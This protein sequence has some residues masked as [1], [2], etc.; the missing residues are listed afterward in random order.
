MAFSFVQVTDHHLTSSESVLTRGFSTNYSF[1]AVMQHIAEYAGAKADPG[2]M[3]PSF[4]VSTGDLGEK[5][6]PGA[7][8]AIGQLLRARM[9]PI[10]MPG[11]LTVSLAGTGET[12]MYFLPGNHD[13]LAVMSRCLFT[14]NEQ[15]RPTSDHPDRL[16]TWFEVG[17]VRFVWLDWGREAKASSTPEMFDFLSLALG[18]GR[19]A[20]ILTHHHVA[21]IGVAWLDGFIADDVHR[22][23]EIVRHKHVLGVLS[24]HVHMTTERVVEGIPVLTLRSTAFQFARQARPLLTLEPPHYRL[25]TIDGDVLTSKV[26]EVA[27]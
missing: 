17:G 16:N 25:V 5:D 27:L 6:P 14:G 13:D 18:E 11:P 15:P 3:A 26:F 10:G 24:G 9:E 4:I 23:W 20:V 1:R 19:P 21:P 8:R 22:F 2:G 12:P 7:Y